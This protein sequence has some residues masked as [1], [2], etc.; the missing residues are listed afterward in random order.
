M[1]LKKL[2]PGL[3]ISVLI[4]A[5]DCSPPPRIES[6]EEQTEEKVTIPSDGFSLF[7]EQR[8]KSVR[9]GNGQTVTISREPFAFQFR[10]QPTAGFLVN[11]S[12]DDTFMT[13]L[14]NGVSNKEIPVLAGGTGIAEGKGNEDRMAYFSAT[15]SNY[16]FFKDSSSTRFDKYRLLY[17]GQILIR[18]IESMRDHRMGNEI[19]MSAFDVDTFYVCVL[20][21]KMDTLT[22]EWHETQ[23]LGFRLAL[24]DGLRVIGDSV[25]IVEEEK[26][27]PEAKEQPLEEP[28][29]DTAESDTIGEG[30]GKEVKFRIDGL[31]MDN[32]CFRLFGKDGSGD[33]VYDVKVCPEQLQAAGN[34]HY[35]ASFTSLVPGLTYYMEV[36]FPN[37]RSYFMLRGK[38]MED[39]LGA[40][41]G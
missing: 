25:E 36:V 11:I 18:T 28:D 22:Y 1:I 16:W 35:E 33:I 14:L 26:L 10:T 41:G 17:N 40:L 13:D 21:Q 38:T 2:L 24:G 7:I 30:A 27:E 34:G 31:P 23:R 3:F 15:G 8:G 19:P 20:T 29:A 9:V 12:R 6:S 5:L 37:G 32:E 39:L 4:C